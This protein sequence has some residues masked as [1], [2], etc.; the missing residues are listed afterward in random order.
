MFS[1]LDAHQFLPDSEHE[2]RV[3]VETA[4]FARLRVNLERLLHLPSEG[5]QAFRVFLFL[6]GY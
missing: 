1:G 2:S 5:L 4:R 3:G 6:A